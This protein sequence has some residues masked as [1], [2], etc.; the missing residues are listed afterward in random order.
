MS[1]PSFSNI[2]L[3]LFELAEG[4][5][6]AD[7]VERLELFLLQN[8]ELD[9]ERD[10]WEFAR[11]DN[12]SVTF[13]DAEELER[14]R[15]PVA[16]Y[17]TSLLVLLFVGAGAYGLW[18]TQSGAD[19]GDTLLAEYN[20]TKQDNLE[21]EN[22]LLRVELA[23][24]IETE[25]LN[26]SGSSKRRD[27]LQSSLA[28]RFFDN[29]EYSITENGVYGSGLAIDGVA[30]QNWFALNAF[31]PR[32][33][34]ITV[35][36]EP[37]IAIS[38]PVPFVSTALVGSALVNEPPLIAS[39]DEPEYLLISNDFYGKHSP[40]YVGRDDFHT[41]A[42]TEIDYTGKHR[43]SERKARKADPSHGGKGN[44][45]KAGLS[46][47]LKRL[48]NKIR[49][50]ADN[51]VALRNSRDPHY[52]V[53]GMTS[54]DISFS[55]AG[56]LVST[57][58]QAMSRIQWLGKENEQLI[59]ELAI[60]GYS[61]GIRGGWGIQLNHAM[62]DDGGIHIGQLAFTYSPKFSVSN[63]IS[64]EP[65]VRFKMG[66]KVL[67]A[68]M[69]AG[70]EQVELDRGNAQ[71]FYSNGNPQIGR[72]L[73][74]RDLGVGLLVNTKWFFVGIQA[75]N[76]FKHQ[77]NIY[78]DDW[79]DPRRAGDH[80]V[81]TIGTDWLSR[82]EDFEL[83]P[84]AVYQKKENFSEVWAGANFRWKGLSVGVAGS[85]L[86]DP[87]ASIGMKFDQFS[88]H[89]NADYTTSSMTG[90]RALSHQVTL[91]LQAKTSRFGQRQF[92][93]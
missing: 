83:S 27:D 52:H 6:S 36:G 19:K 4:N 45:Y 10:M 28:S 5:L 31:P 56:T 38:Q 15:R 12:T 21:R 80:I 64:V 43:W 73:W 74:Y 30:Y 87:A 2:D 68:D 78:S 70:T 82:S 71:D 7:Q 69:L 26:E 61:Y 77:D 29:G 34:G 18:T 1:K 46:I 22:T 57:K 72:N 81:A 63:W 89:Y 84:Y 51:P 62:Y 54:N 48:S 35:N 42:V 50:M 14:K 55:S 66:D 40:G 67:N 59:N 17:L 24:R 8:P 33:N 20:K 93:L 86:L 49:Q 47:K 3:W 88:L 13:P 39:I 44:D 75:D 41:H 65:S 60:D 79:S 91:R 90:E 16:L 37:L 23:K 53:P 25:N 11:V 85:S 32:V 58:V 76:L 92:K 9:I